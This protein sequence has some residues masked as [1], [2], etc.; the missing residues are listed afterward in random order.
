M[1]LQS[2][3]A[4]AATTLLVAWGA[5][6]VWAVPRLGDI[7]DAVEIDAV[8]QSIAQP[9]RVWG[10]KSMYLSLHEPLFRPC[11]ACEEGVLLGA[12]GGMSVHRN[13]RRIRMLAVGD[14]FT[15][16]GGLT[17]LDARWWV[18]LE[19]DLNRRT[20]DGVFE[21][22]ALG[23]SGTSTFTH[24]RWLEEVH[25]YGL[26]PL[27][28][29]PEENTREAYDVIV[30]GYIGNDVVVGLGEKV[31]G[32]DGL[33]LSSIEWSQQ[34]PIIAGDQPIPHIEAYLRLPGRIRQAVGD[35]PVLLAQLMG[36]GP[37]LRVDNPNGLAAAWTKAGV[38]ILEMKQTM[39]MLDERDRADLIVN[40]INQHSGAALYAANAR[41]IADAVL[42]QI[43]PIR[44]GAAKSGAVPVERPTLTVVLPYETTIVG[45]DDGSITLQWSST[46]IDATWCSSAGSGLP[47]TQVDCG[48]WTVLGERVPAQRMPCAELGRPHILVL[49][50]RNETGS[51]NI[52]VV[53]DKVATYLAYSYGYGSDGWR[54]VESLGRV[55][56]GETFSGALGGGTTGFA[57]A[58]EGKDTYEWAADTEAVMD[59][60]DLVISG[61]RT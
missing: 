57:I 7:Q 26:G 60:V 6:G 52:R 18:Q 30:L 38:S 55:A 33:E 8:N 61:A 32:D 12:P 23:K 39:H 36:N 13:E 51:R 35:V 48:V 17:D 59:P 28:G 9:D 29:E 43:D 22:V 44:L 4:L 41:D 25:Q 10:S 24:T 31:V 5:I 19:K 3:R 20:G 16:G 34:A 50:N 1:K 49:F 21:V 46:L 2:R 11:P 54:V 45:G 56:A 42:G 40:P 58:E 14:S 27:G 15:V 37:G 53:S 47:G